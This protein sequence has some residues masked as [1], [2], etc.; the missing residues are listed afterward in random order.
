MGELT[1]NSLPT[2]E[3]IFHAAARMFAEHGYD[4]VSMRDLASAVG[5][6]N[7]SIYNHFASKKEILRELY[8]FFHYHRKRLL[9]DLNE[10]IEEANADP[11]LKI[12]MEM[13]FSFDPG[14]EETMHSILAIAARQISTD[15]ESRQF[16]IEN[17]LSAPKEQTRPVLEKL[18]ELKR[19]QPMDLD[20]FC[21]LVMHYL[22]GAVALVAT[23]LRMDSD[24]WK[25]GLAFIYS[26]FIKPI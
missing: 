14:I 1:Q 10:A 19:I 2:K 3:R 23:P 24:A 22:F 25:K 12:L 8:A 20:A 18:V 13:V 15:A 16:I 5:I 26:T 11:P 9:P 7:P 4:N 21:N 17:I 6:K